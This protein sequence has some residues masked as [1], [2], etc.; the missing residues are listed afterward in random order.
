MSKPRFANKWYQTPPVNELRQEIQNAYDNLTVVEDEKIKNAGSVPQILAGAATA[1]DSDGNPTPNTTD[2]PP[3]KYD[4]GTLFFATSYPTGVDGGSMQFQ[5]VSGAWVWK[6]GEYSASGTFSGTGS[7]N[8][9]RGAD[10]RQKC[11]VVLSATVTG[12]AIGNVFKGTV[13]SWSFPAT[14]ISSPKIVTSVEFVTFDPFAARYSGLTTTSVT[15]VL[16]GASVT[17]E[18]KPHLVAVGRWKV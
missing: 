15:V 9:T 10:G 7:G 5:Q 13:G 14:F 2:F 12:T 3:A 18:G 8:Y 16:Y 11:E 4:E 17:S 6:W 1:T